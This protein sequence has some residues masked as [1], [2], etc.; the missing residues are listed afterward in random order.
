MSTEM[1][2]YRVAWAEAGSKEGEDRTK[3]QAAALGILQ[4]ILQRDPRFRDLVYQQ[5]AGQIPDDAKVET[6][7]PMEQLA[8]AYVHSQGQK[9]DTPESRAELARAAAAAERVHDNPAA[10]AEDKLEATFLAGVTNGLLNNL[11]A[12]AR[13]N[14]EFAEQAPKDPRAKPLLDAALEQI[15]ELRKTAAM[16]AADS[17]AL[18]SLQGRALTLATD[19]FHDVK[20]RYAQGARWRMREGW[21][22]RRRFLRAFQRTTRITWMRGSG[23]LR[24][25]HAV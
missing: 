8:V 3:A 19:N 5:L 18:L 17:S 24:L 22:M 4:N 15:G 12:A 1:L 20:W 25:Q 2:A 23:S 16:S 7:L 9:G 21:T 10:P 13:Y 11:A 6:L 14:V